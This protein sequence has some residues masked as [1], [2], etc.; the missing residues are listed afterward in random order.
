MTN[1][2]EEP[3]CPRQDADVNT[4]I[5]TLGLRAKM[6]KDGESGLCSATDGGLGKQKQ[7]FQG[8]QEAHGIALQCLSCWPLRSSWNSSFLMTY[9]R[10]CLLQT[11]LNILFFE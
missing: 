8:K 7:V 10:S 9:K 6:S 1:G 11:S 4:R 3:A 2:V 5:H